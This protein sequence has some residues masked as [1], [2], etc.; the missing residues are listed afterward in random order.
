MEKKRLLLHCCCAPCA[1][2]AID[3]LNAQYALTLF[4]CNPTIYPLSEYE[5]RLGELK[6][7]SI[8]FDL[9]L[10]EGSRVNEV[11][12]RM[13]QYAQEREG[14]KR[15]EICLGDRLQKSAEFAAANAFDLFATSLTLS[16]LKSAEKINATGKVWADKYQIAYLESNFKK[17]NGVLRSVEL[18]EKYGVYR[19]TYCGC[20][21][22]L[23]GSGG[24]QM[25]ENN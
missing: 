10:I 25:R 15:C 3:R 22:S 19:Q 8:V 7:I 20:A 14:G 23:N 18:C 6:K 13:A 12:E 5:K 1:L 21:F 17:Q 9:P 2:T 4:F 11:A 24:A 16:P